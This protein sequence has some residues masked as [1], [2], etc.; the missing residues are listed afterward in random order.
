MI[1]SLETAFVPPFAGGIVDVD[2]AQLWSSLNMAPS[3]WGGTVVG[4]ATSRVGC[5]SSSESEKTRHLR[6]PVG[7]LPAP[8]PQPPG[9]S[10]AAQHDFWSPKCTRPLRP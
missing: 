2:D 4:V 7:P 3:R 6:P 5:S 10:V 8:H 9:C 1:V